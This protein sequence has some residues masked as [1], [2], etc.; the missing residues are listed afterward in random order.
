MLNWNYWNQITKTG[1]KCY[2]LN[3]LFLLIKLIILFI[4]IYY[5]IFYFILIDL[6]T[7]KNI[8]LFLLIKCILFIIYYNI[9]YF[10]SIKIL[11][12]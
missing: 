11:F 10:A 6:N 5:K 3:W 9:F 4:I 8:V 2:N 7:N 1:L 12:Y